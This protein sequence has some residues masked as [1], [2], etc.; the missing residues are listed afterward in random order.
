MF[1]VIE[2]PEPAYEYPSFYCPECN[3]HSENKE[4]CATDILGRLKCPTCGEF[5]LEG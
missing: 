2:P 4:E 3:W 1:D 5:L